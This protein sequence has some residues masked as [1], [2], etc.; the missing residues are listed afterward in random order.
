[1]SVLS[2]EVSMKLVTRCMAAFALMFVAASARSA[3]CEIKESTKQLDAVEVGFCESDAVFVGVSE[4][5]IETV[6]GLTDAA[7]KE[8]HFRMQ[9]STLRIVESYKGKLLERAVLIAN[10]YDKQ[11]AFVFSY[12]KKYLVFA[13]KL[14]GDNEYAGA[15]A[16]CSVQPTLLIEQAEQ[17][18]LRLQQHRSGAKPIDC[19]NISS[20][21]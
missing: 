10:L 1:M 20:K 11:G 5:A 8:K 6:G 12:G 14:S 13:K 3:E 15:S 16:A 7:G 21:R 2:A 17:A 9:R 18:V 19:A 4:G